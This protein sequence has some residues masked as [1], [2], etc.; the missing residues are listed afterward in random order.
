M[1]AIGKRSIIITDPCCFVKDEDWGSGFDLDN[2]T[3]NVP[4]FS[5]YVWKST[6]FGDGKGKVYL[7]DKPYSQY[8]LEEIIIDFRKSKP[9]Q[10]FRDLGSFCV[11]SGTFGAFFYDEVLEYYP[12]FALDVGSWCYTVIPDFNGAIFDTALD[13]SDENSEEDNYYCYNYII[14]SGNKSICTV[15]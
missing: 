7:S 5:D 2:Y 4:E 1:K 11:D 10:D 8:E 15:W 3:I 12:N 6:G 13:E 9:H 14:G